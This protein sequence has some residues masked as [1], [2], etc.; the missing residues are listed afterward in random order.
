MHSLAA[1]D[2]AELCEREGTI[3]VTLSSDGWNE[4]SKPASLLNIA[5]RPHAQHGLDATIL[6]RCQLLGE[7]DVIAS[8]AESSPCSKRQTT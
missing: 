8:N 4:K 5:S 7:Q 2:K 6:A 3:F 1:L